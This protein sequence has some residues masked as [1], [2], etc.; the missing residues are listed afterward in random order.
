MRDK[1]TW[2]AEQWRKYHFAHDDLVAENAK[3]REEL[4]NTTADLETA[5]AQLDAVRDCQT[6][7]PSV[8]SETDRQGKP[9][10]VLRGMVKDPT[11]EYVLKS[12]INKALEQKESE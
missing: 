3:L 2:T 8:K 11:G 9:R 7:L 6:Y 12:D 10:Q 1:L 5:Q 4:F